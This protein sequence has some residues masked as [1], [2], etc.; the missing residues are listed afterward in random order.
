MGM[1]WTIASFTK[2]NLKY[3]V[4]LDD[5]GLW[6]C[7]CPDY[8]IRKKKIHGECK[9]IKSLKGVPINQQEIDEEWILED[10]WIIS[11]AEKT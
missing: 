3:T 5:T 6:E 9:H 2:P 7:S 11:L 8:Y 4:H 10:E 1:K